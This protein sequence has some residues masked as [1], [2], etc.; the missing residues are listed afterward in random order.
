M[1]AQ[2]SERLTQFKLDGDALAQLRAAGDLVIPD[3]DE[4]LSG[5][6]DRALNT[7]SSA[8]FFVSDAM[9]T[10]ARNKQKEHWQRLLSGELD[11]AYQKSVDRIGRTH[12]RINL[13]LDQYMSAYALAS[14]DLISRLLKRM[15]RRFGR[16]GAQTSEYVSVISR[17]FAF[18]I[19]QVTTITFR[20]WGEEQAAAFAHLNHAIEALS[21]GDLHH[22][23]PTPETSDFPKRYDVTRQ[24]MNEALDKLSGMISDISLATNDLLSVVDKVAQASEDMSMRTNSQAAS[25]EETA[26]AMEQMVQNVRESTT[27][28]AATNQVAG[29]AKERVQDSSEVVRRSHQAVQRIKDASDKIGQITSLIDDISFQTNLL[30]LNAGVEAA[31][32]GD[33]GRGFAVVASEVRTLAGNSSNAAREI[34]ELIAASA[35]EVQ[36]GVQLISSARETLDSTAR[37]FE[38]L[39][40]LSSE[41]TVASEQQADAIAEVNNAMSQ[42]DKITQDNAAMV[43]DTHRDMQRMRDG[44]RRIHELLSAFNLQ[45]QAIRMH[46]DQR[47]QSAA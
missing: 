29:T 42:M 46:S 35:S 34:K 27:N 25:L 9:I 30:A 13:P 44:S 41:V 31:R 21:N 32:A 36:E 5:F 24:K 22:R 3:L 38:E 39:A 17:A 33:A 16:S 11:E 1:N 43:D 23:I 2:F 10:H 45:E 14:S 47:G 7:P 28:I 8:A 18:D 20:V 19:E 15:K 12:A 40:R 37:N 4:V 6:Y 26:A